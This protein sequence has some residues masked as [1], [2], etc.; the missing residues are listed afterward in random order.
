M[1]AR[2]HGRGTLAAMGRRFALA[3]VLVCGVASGAGAHVE[4]GL[5]R[6]L[7][8]AAEDASVPTA[9]AA[10]LPTGPGIFDPPTLPDYDPASARRLA[11]AG[12]YGGLYGGAAKIGARLGLE[13]DFEIVRLESAWAIDVF[14]HIYAVR[15]L[16]R[17]F[18][19]LHRWAGDDPRTARRRGAWYAGFGSLLY[20]ETINGFMPGVRFD[21]LDPVSNAAGAWL[22][23][24]GQDFAAR[25]PWTQRFTYEIGYKSW[26]QLGEP[27]RQTGPLTRLWHDYPNTRYGLG[28]GIGPVRRPWLRIF[29]TY[30]VTSLE[31]DELRNQFGMGVEFAPHH[32]VAPL[33]ERAPLG[34]HLLAFVDAIDRHVMLPVLYVHLFDVETGPFSNR[35]PFRE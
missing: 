7:P 30:G 17:A 35:R 16:S 8:L 10:D 9:A 5:L 4:T 14:G 15:H 31:L 24:G 25:H 26:S 28:Y 27:D 13:R 29:A 21:W 2:M 3:V 33:V 19:S 18:A 34:R 20:M 22:A 12:A 23:D 11:L 6:E 1:N 32:W